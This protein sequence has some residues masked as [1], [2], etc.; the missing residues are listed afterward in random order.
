MIIANAGTTNLGKVDSLNEIADLSKKHDIWMHVDGAYGGFFKIEK[1]SHLFAGIE[2]GFYCFRSAA[3]QCFFHTV[4]VQYY[5][6]G[7]FFLRE[8]S[9]NASYLQDSERDCSFLRWI[10]QLNLV[11]L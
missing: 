2:H 4:V 6:K 9:S 3:K 5:L 1:T 11:D 10:I 7:E 8:L